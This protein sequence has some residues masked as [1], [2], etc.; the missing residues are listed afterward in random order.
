VEEE[1]AQITSTKVL[2]NLKLLG[3]K[4]YQTCEWG[5]E[6]AQITGTKVL[7]NLKLVVLN[8]VLQNLPVCAAASC[9]NVAAFAS[10]FVLL[11]Q[12][13]RQH[14]H[15]RTSKASKLSTCACVAAAALSL[16]RI[17][18]CTFVPVKQVN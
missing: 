10:V 4:Y 3:L 8:K 1:N 14:L 17:S 9:E 5:R 7:Q 6:D 16:M 11:Y 18:I 2:Q 15:F 12:Y 13:A